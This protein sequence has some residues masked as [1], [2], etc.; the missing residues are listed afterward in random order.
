M[1][2]KIGSTLEGL[3]E[4]IETYIVR[5]EYAARARHRTI[6]DI[7][8][9]KCGTR[10]MKENLLQKAMEK[11]NLTY[12]LDKSVFEL[13]IRSDDI[14]DTFR[15]FDGK[16][17]FF[18]AGSRQDPDNV[19]VLQH[20][21]RMLLREGRLTLALNQIDTAIQKDRTK[22]IRSLHHTRGLILA[23]LSLTD[24][25]MDVARKWLAQSAQEFNY[26]MAAKESDSYGHSGLATLYLKWSR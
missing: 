7:V 20:F 11:L 6:A 21:A 5:G 15:T 26:C 8:W 25:N 13:F 19:Y 16:I 9:K 14:V 23:G 18:E 22:A 3:V 2:S 17:K 10:D 1:H 4:Y 12:R 24:E